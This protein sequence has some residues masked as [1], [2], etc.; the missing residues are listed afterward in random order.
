MPQ[1]YLVW[2]CFYIH[3]YILS[4]KGIQLSVFKLSWNVTDSL[5]KA[6]KRDKIKRRGWEKNEGKERKKKKRESSR[7]V[8]FSSVDG[9]LKTTLGSLFHRCLAFPQAIKALSFSL[10]LVDFS[11][12]SLPTLFLSLSSPFSRSLTAEARSR[13]SYGI[14]V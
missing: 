5:R 8:S 10:K 2:K 1:I 11:T 9:P 7:V 4:I 12:F 6:L 13:E 3:T 14:Y